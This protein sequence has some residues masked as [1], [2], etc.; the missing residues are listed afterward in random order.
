MNKGT[1]LVVIN[2]TTIDKEKQSIKILEDLL[3][4]DKQKNDTKSIKYHALA[5]NN[6]KEKLIQLMKGM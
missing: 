1:M 4:K 5:L 3:T 2:N 6:H